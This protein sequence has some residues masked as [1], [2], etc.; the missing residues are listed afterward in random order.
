MGILD[1]SLSRII[2]NL[3]ILAEVTQVLVGGMIDPGQWR[4]I[5]PIKFIHHKQHEQ[6][7]R[8]LSDKWWQM[9]SLWTQM[10]CY[11]VEVWLP[12]LPSYNRACL[13]T[14][15]SAAAIMCFSSS[16][17]WSSDRQCTTNSG[18]K[19]HRWRRM[20][21]L[22][23]RASCGSKCSYLMRS[24]PNARSC[25]TATLLDKWFVTTSDWRV[26]FHFCGQQIQSSCLEYLWITAVAQVMPN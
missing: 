22:A 15:H 4:L 6:Q 17:R 24:Y 21:V 16:G 14:W 5:E 25:L 13:L 1:C 8:P 18:V 26:I 19:Y 20:L 12:R 7:P 10:G 9:M 23:A 11:R 3:E 2:H